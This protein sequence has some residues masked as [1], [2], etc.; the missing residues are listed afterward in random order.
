MVKPR[1]SIVMPAH[2]E[3]ANIPLLY[4]ELKS[5]LDKIGKPWEIILVDDGSNDG[6]FF[7]AKAINLKDKRFRVVRFRKN[8]GQTA[9]LDAGFKAAKGEIIISLDADLQDDPSEIPKF[10]QKLDEGWDVVCGWRFK[11]HDSI[12]KRL[13]SRLANLLRR[14]FLGPGVHDAGCTFRAYRSEALKNLAL[15]GE[16][17]RYLPY[18]LM[19][20]GFKVTEIKI[21]HRP[22]RFGKTKYG[23]TRLP[24]GIIDMFIMKFWMNYSA[25]PGHLFGG[26]GFFLGLIGLLIGGWLVTEKAL[27]GSQL[28]NR[29]LLLLSVL[30][31]VLGAQFF[32]FGVLADILVKIYYKNLTPYEIEK[33]LK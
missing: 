29:P 26:L 27:F 25:R 31:V 11:R 33:V 24:K 12:S 18:L 17:H 32:L 4:A 15:F 5:V 1:I 10:L 28:A 19:W 13:F 6:T 7:E 2:N 30:L 9:A 14:I 3:R 23:L 16:M 8:F 20:K 21:N 22:R